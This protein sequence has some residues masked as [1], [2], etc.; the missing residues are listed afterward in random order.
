MDG[1]P[2]Q[3]DRIRLIGRLFF[4]LGGR[5]YS[6]V[7]TSK[8]SFW[9]AIWVSIISTSVIIISELTFSG[10]FPVGIPWAVFGFLFATSFIAISSILEGVKRL[11][12][13]I[14]GGLGGILVGAISL[15]AWLTLF[16]DQLPC[17]L[18][19]QGC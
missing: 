6:L 2:S 16:L 19:G 7:M 10:G 13:N 14:F 5:S 17:F 15:S 12:L 11:K 4:Q 3:E 18:G 9:V 8:C 1:D